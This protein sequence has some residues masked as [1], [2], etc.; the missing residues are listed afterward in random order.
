MA[1]VTTEERPTAAERRV[2]GRINYLGPMSE[3]PRYYA[4]DSSRDVL[5]LEETA[6]QIRDVRA[7]ASPPSIDREGFMLT[8]HVS[9][10]SDFRDQAEVARVHPAEI[11]ALL[12]KITGADRVA[13]SGPGVLRFGE[14]SKD[15]G[16][17]NNSR[18]ARFVHIDVSDETAAGFAKRSNPEPDRKVRRYANYN[19]WRVI[20]DPPQDVPLAVC[21][22]RSLAP[23][24]LV[25]ADA[26]FDSATA[27]EWSF[28][29][30]VVR[31]NP[32]HRWSY[33]SGMTRDEA[34]VF[35]TKDSDPSAAHHVPHSA[36]DDPT[37][38]AGVSPRASIEMR[39]I[40][41]WYE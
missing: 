29:G 4:N 17:L 9:A 20:S 38:P 13:V 3:R 11:E 35:K 30:L 19:V 6:V 28:V 39:G 40:A 7:A 37:C 33:F 23:Q 31:P 8:P 18:P 22:A 1:N 36:F 12:L 32:D 21:D 14:K 25:E 41:Y 16:S 24:D 27:P 10:V 5:V 34:L 26:V 2:T 15:S